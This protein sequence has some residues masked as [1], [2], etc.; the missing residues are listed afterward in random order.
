MDLERVRFR[1]KQLGNDI[2]SVIKYASVQKN[3]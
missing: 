2:M 1:L 3:L